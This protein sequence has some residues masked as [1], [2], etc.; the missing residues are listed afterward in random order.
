MRGKE[1]EI[2]AKMVNEIVVGEVDCP[3]CGKTLILIHREK[4][5]SHKTLKHKVEEKR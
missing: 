2:P 3:K 1:R 5:G 4:T